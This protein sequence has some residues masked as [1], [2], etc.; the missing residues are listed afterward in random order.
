MLFYVNVEVDCCAAVHVYLA[1]FYFQITVAVFQLKYPMLGKAGDW[2]LFS[3][4]AFSSSGFLMRFPFIS[5]LILSKDKII[6]S[7]INFAR[8]LYLAAVCCVPSEATLHH[9]PSS[10]TRMGLPTLPDRPHSPWLAPVLRCSQ[11]PYCSKAN[12]TPLLSS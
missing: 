11:L 7:N 9:V 12:L 3:I 5:A 8:D 2:T 1:K 4:S 6:L 10:S